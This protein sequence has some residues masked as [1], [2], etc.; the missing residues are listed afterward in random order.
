MQ[1]FD[2]MCGTGRR[3]QHALNLSMSS[4]TFPCDKTKHDALTTQ[5]SPIRSSRRLSPSVPLVAAPA[6]ATSLRLLPRSF[7]LLPRSLLRYGV[8]EASSF[9]ERV[10]VG[11][12]ECDIAAQGFSRL[13]W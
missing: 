9:L 10:G 12:I 5:S 1:N 3:K 8:P 13:F 2:K 7:H 6:T 11:I 4:N